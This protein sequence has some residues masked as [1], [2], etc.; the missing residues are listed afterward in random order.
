MDTQKQ[1]EEKVKLGMLISNLGIKP[2]EEVFPDGISEPPVLLPMKEKHPVPIHPIVKNAKAMKT[3]L[4]SSKDF[5][6]YTIVPALQHAG[7]Q[8][9]Q[10][11][12]YIA[13]NLVE[14]FRK[15]WNSFLTHSDN[16]Y[17][18]IIHNRTLRNHLTALQTELLKSFAVVMHVTSAYA[19]LFYTLF[20]D[21]ATHICLKSEPQVN[22]I[23]SKVSSSVSFK[24]FE[25]VTS[26]VRKLQM[27]ISEAYWL[28][29]DRLLQKVLDLKAEM[30]PIQSHICSQKESAVALCFE[31][32]LKSPDKA[33]QCIEPLETYKKCIDA[34][35]CNL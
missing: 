29:R 31:G 17:S 8:S 4:A 34:Y 21:V 22:A 25:K 32:L 26:E 23:I 10:I 20:C 12:R 6:S 9:Y 16:V 3:H 19:Q 27:S 1:H 30:R 7:V 2:Q 15:V 28:V 33:L 18:S 13:I 24:T 35:T 14:N 11:F 5:L